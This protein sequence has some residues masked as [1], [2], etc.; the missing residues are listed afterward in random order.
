MLPGC[1]SCSHATFRVEASMA[2][3]MLTDRS[4]HPLAEPT[5][6]S[7]KKGHLNRREYLATMAAFGVTA[8]GSFAL[9][10]IAPTPVQAQEVKRGGTL[11]V[12]M[13]VKPFRDP[14]SF[15]GVEMSN[16]SRQCCEYLVRWNRDFTFEPWLLESWETSDDAS[17]LTL[18]VRRNVTWSNGDIFNTDDVVH[19]LIRW[20]DAAAPGNSVAS[21]I[22]AIINPETKKLADGA[23]EKVDEFTIRI[24]M[25]KPDVSLIAGFCD[26]PAMIMHRSYRGETDPMKALAIT[27]GPCE[28]VSWEAGERAEVRRK[29][30]PWW[31]GDFYLDGITWT[32]YGA[33][34]NV[35]LAAFES[36]EIDTNHET[37]ADTL[38]QAES[39]GLVN[40]E[41]ATAST[42]VARFNVNQTPFDDHKMRRAAQL[43]VDNAAI[44]KLGIADRGSVA[45]NHHVSPIHADYAD[46]GPAQR[47]LDEAKRLFGE[48]GNVGYEYELISVDD[49]WQKNTADA[50]AAQM[51]EAGMKVKR[52]VLPA[53]TYWNDWNKYPF[54]CTEWLGRPLGVQVLALAYKSGAAWNESA[55]SDK[56]FDELLDKALATPKVEER[57]ALM[58]KSE[59]ILR[60]AGVIIQPYWRSVYRTSRVGVH[61]CEQHQALEQ[62]FEKAWIET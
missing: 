34:P 27:T 4:L 13:N 42:I 22:G 15:D 30:Q 6:E 60:D 46:I 7:F 52:T 19:N 53:S 8:A 55:F 56:G 12:A 39:I 33:D 40:S 21:R 9:G 54:S 47:N 38:P 24:R 11:R 37:Y 61:G 2:T 29:A 43:A 59:Q 36:S 16:I 58:A 48:A 51:R 20:S 44:L 14:R 35:M 41:I 28:L 25:S 10:G 31:K 49:E 32:D 23:V 17:E 3:F 57:K 26:Y 18:H 5:A 50:I 62:H 45:A 1:L